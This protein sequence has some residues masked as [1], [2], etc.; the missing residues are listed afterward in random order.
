MKTAVW[1]LATWQP[2]EAVSQTIK[3][4]PNAESALLAYIGC[5]VSTVCARGTEGAWVSRWCRVSQGRTHAHAELHIAWYL[6]IPCAPRVDSSAVVPSYYWYRL[7]AC[8][9][10]FQCISSF[11]ATTQAC[12]LVN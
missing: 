5:V 7:V 10:G 8:V 11:S 12:N 3:Y 6:V 1:L 2:P 9:R 4:E